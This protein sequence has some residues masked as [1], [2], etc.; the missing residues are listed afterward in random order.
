MEATT[1]LDRQLDQ[2]DEGALVDT[3]TAVPRILWT[4][5]LLAA[6]AAPLLA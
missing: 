2:T 5:G 6:S 3:H 1:W 4:L